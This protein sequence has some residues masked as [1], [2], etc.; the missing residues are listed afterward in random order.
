MPE[1]VSVAVIGSGPAGAA[2]ALLVARAGID[3]VLFERSGGGRADRGEVLAAEG[4]S[5]LFRMALW[6][7]RPPTAM[8]PCE[9]IHSAWRSAAATARTSITNPYGCAW[10]VTVRLRTPGSG[11]R[12]P[13]PFARAVRAGVLAA[14]GA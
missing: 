3:V 12:D 11:A 2:T 4:R 1:A 6:E 14:A 7:R 13:R 9:S 8:R 5:V 10:Y